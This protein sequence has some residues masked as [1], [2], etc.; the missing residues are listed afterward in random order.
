MPR[1]AMHALFV[2]VFLCVSTVATLAQHTE[3]NS[4]MVGVDCESGD[5][6]I[7]DEEIAAYPE[8]N[9]RQ[10]YADDKL[11]FDRRYRRVI[12]ATDFHDAPGGTVAEGLG[13]GFN[14]ITLTNEES[15]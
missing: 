3:S 13:Q 7:S 2:F 15:E 9:V 12:G 1:P 5:F 11:V 6:G 4:C 10:V 14:F 8:P